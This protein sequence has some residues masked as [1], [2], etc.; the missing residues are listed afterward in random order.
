MNNHPQDSIV[1][2]TSDITRQSDS[3][4]SKEQ[5]QEQEQEENNLEYSLRPSLFIYPPTPPPS[6]SEFVIESSPSSTTATIGRE[7][8]SSKSKLRRTITPGFHLTAEH[9][10]REVVPNVPSDRQN[11]VKSSNETNV[12]VSN[13]LCLCFSCTCDGPK[14]RTFDDML[15]IFPTTMVWF[16][17]ICLP[18]ICCRHDIDFCCCICWRTQ[19]SMTSRENEK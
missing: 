6:E 10:E 13:P 7:N 11:T 4:Y 2:D 17:C 12:P 1:S 16:E 18:R 15:Y 9:M 3:L 8:T 14:K 5:Q 19:R